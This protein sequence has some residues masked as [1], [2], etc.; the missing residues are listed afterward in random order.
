MEIYNVNLRAKSLC[1][2]L[3]AIIDVKIK[4]FRFS[5]KIGCFRIPLADDLEGADAMRLLEQL[6]VSMEDTETGKVEEMALSELPALYRQLQ[7]DMAD[8]YDSPEDEGWDID[9]S[10]EEGMEIDNSEKEASEIDNPEVENWE[11]SL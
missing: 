8:K 7:V 10:G 6:Q 2:R 5:L 4:K 11:L 1:V 3:A 9:D